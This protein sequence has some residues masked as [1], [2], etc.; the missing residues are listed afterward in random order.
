MVLRVPAVAQ[1]VKNLTAIQEDA[2][3]T[4]GLLQWDKDLALLQAEVWQ[5][6][7]APWIQCCCG[8]GISQHL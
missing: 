8:C 1:Q 2:G 3:L 6:Q 5:E 4:P 7:D